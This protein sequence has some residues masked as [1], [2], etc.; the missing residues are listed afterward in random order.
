M[1]ERIRFKPMRDQQVRRPCRRGIV[2]VA[3]VGTLVI[4]AIAG[5]RRR[6][7]EATGMTEPR[8][9]AVEESSWESF[10]ASDAPGWIRDHV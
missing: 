9:D 7:H 8:P 1:S 10:P 3:L 2:T 4:L 6:G 5:A